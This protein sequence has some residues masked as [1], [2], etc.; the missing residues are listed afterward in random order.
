MSP[1]LRYDDDSVSVSI[2]TFM[3]KSF[4]EDVLDDLSNV[5]NYEDNDSE[6]LFKF[7]KMELNEERL[8]SGFPTILPLSESA[9]PAGD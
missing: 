7:E 9:C 2:D 5:L 6:V 4:S 3:D 1:R 8:G